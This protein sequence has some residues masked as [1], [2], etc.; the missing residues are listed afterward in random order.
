MAR[1]IV[2][3]I[4]CVCR[5]DCWCADSCSARL[6]DG[7]SLRLGKPRRAMLCDGLRRS[8]DVWWMCS[9]GESAKTESA[10]KA[11]MRTAAEE[12]QPGESVCGMWSRCHLAQSMAKGSGAGCVP[13][14]SRQR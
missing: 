14:V 13:E 5:T 6:C 10:P 11:C 2:R 4:I 7:N 9:R 8:K 1:C 3:D 12:L